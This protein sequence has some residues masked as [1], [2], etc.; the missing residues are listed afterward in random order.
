MAGRTRGGFGQV[1]EIGAK[2]D[3]EF[4][5]NAIFDRV[6][7]PP[8]GR[9]GGGTGAG[10]WVVPPVVVDGVV[11]VGDV[12]VVGGV[13]PVDGSGGA[14]VSVAPAQSASAGSQAEGAPSGRSAPQATSP[15]QPAA[16]KLANM[17]PTASG[18][19]I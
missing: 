17:P 18:Y 7:N 8:K 13:G 14:A 1:M 4:A 10:G 11:A 19:L 5:V 3:A 16:K 9:E 12:P 15:S 2:A 6:A